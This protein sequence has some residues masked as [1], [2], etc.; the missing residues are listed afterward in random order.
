[1]IGF[2]ET[3]ILRSLEKGLDAASTRHQVIADNLANVDTPGYKR[4]EVQF[5]DELAAVIDREA[6]GMTGKRSDPRHIPLNGGIG[7]LSV[8]VVTQESESFRNDGN[9]VDV[10]REMALL[11]KNSLW[12]NG[13]INTISH[14]LSGIKNV[15]QGVR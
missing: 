14:K 6:S 10:D 15:L 9:N 4:K 11:A 2:L 7:D 8:R 5:E 3:P 12:Y 13:M 1:M